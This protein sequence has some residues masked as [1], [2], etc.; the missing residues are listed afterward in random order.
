MKVLFVKLSA[1]GDIIHCLPA[2][3]DVLNHPAVTEVHWLVDQRYAFV[4]DVLPGKVHIHTV[5]LK[6]EHPVSAAWQCIQSLR[7]LKFDAIIDLQGLIK[8]ALIARACGPHVYGFDKKFMREKAGNFLIHNVPFHADEKHVVQY[9]RR[10]ASAPFKEISTEQCIPYRAP[11]IQ[12]EQSH[13]RADP[14]I[15]ERVGLT[16][17]P[18]VMLH[19]AGGWE[20]KQLPEQSWIDIAKGLRELGIQPLFTW[21]S[22]A[23]QKQAQSLASASS[24]YALPERLDMSALSALIQKAQN[25]VGAD[26]GLLHLA[27]ALG[28]ATVT[29][30]GP[31]ASWRSGPLNDRSAAEKGVKH[32]FIESSPACGPCFKRKC[33]NFTCMETIQASAILDA[34]NKTSSPRL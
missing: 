20:T 23:E 30:W 4:T 29:F 13:C 18:F 6:G 22:A 11:N 15:I 25:V 10:I 32:W 5:A 28:C 26:T 19:A 8:S 27:A 17:K 12:L 7:A 3:D 16:D 21:G 33:D 24:G 14:D 1:F 34:I 31:S 9:Y 2:L